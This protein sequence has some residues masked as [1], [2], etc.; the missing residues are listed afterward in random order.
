M[1]KA[2]ICQFSTPKLELVSEVL[3]KAKIANIDRLYLQTEDL[4]G[5]LYCQFGF[6][7]LHRANSK[8]VDVTVMCSEIGANKKSD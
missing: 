8:G 5:G 2:L 6:N 4:S 3:N 1:I 7:H